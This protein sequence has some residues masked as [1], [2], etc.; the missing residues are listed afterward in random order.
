MRET[1]SPRAAALRSEL[2]R[3]LIGE[4][5]YTPEERSKLESMAREEYFA[6]RRELLA[7]SITASKATQ[8][9][10][11]SRQTLY[12]RAKAGTLLTIMENGHLHF[13]KWQFDPDRENG[14]VTGLPLVLSKIKVPAFSQAAWLMRP[15]PYLE[16]RTPIEALKAGELESVIGLAQAVGV[17]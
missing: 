17:S 12:N 16:G 5:T 13:P 2:L 7:G 9:V 14:V 8:I 11:V 10:G 6:Q 15:N 4:R 3:R 1:S